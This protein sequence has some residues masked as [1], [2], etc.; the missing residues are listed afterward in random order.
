LSAP[1]EQ[2]DRSARLEAN[3]ARGLERYASGDLLGAAAEWREG[4]SQAPG[5][6]Q[7]TAY[8]AWLEF[9]LASEDPDLVALR[10]AAGPVARSPS[11]EER[12][13][14][15]EGPEVMAPL[16]ALADRTI[17]LGSEPPPAPLPAGSAPRSPG[18]VHSPFRGVEAPVRRFLA[19]AQTKP[20]LVPLDVPELTDERLA[21]LAGVPARE[22]PPPEDELD[23]PQLPSLPAAI[24]ATALPP[25]LSAKTPPGPPRGYPGPGPARPPTPPWSIAPPPPPPPRAE[26]VLDYVPQ[27]PPPA[28]TMQGLG[29]FE[30]PEMTSWA[31]S[32]TPTIEVSGYPPAMTLPDEAVPQPIRNEG[33]TRKN[34][35][36]I[37]ESIKAMRRAI[38]D[39]DLDGALKVAEEVVSFAGNL[40]QP[41]L[42]AHASALAAVY[43]RALGDRSRLVRMGRL[44]PDLDPRSAFLLSRVDG[45][46]TVDDLLDIS[47]MERTEAFRL[48]AILMRSGALLA[49]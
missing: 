17:P 44:P 30:L 41:L 26:P 33:P 5:D 15:Y 32:P 10:G 18:P 12:S 13:A 16:G 7:L 36:P 8:L 38:D 14:I 22:P 35:S 39:D 3:L 47:G 24:A 34:G 31:T 4:L 1:A 6:V 45:S 23:P 25:S 27:P 9:R 21:E 11:T 37:T 42:T 19:S 29:G 20:N 48:V 2:R 40:D 43:E 28:G 49:G 46:F